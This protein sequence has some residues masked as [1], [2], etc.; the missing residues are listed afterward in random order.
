VKYIQIIFCTIII[1]FLG[2]VG[3][4]TLDNKVAS[5]QDEMRTYTMFP[6]LDY[7]KLTDVDYLT[8]IGD[9]FT[10]QLEWRWSFV[11]GY[12]TLTKDILHQS[13]LGSIVVGK[14]Q[15]L[16]NE[17][18]N[19]KNW[20]KYKKN[21]KKGAELLNEIAEEA[22][23]YGTKLIV[24]DAPR[25][26][27]ALR[28]YVPSWYPDITDQYEE[29][30]AIQR[31][32]LD[33]SIE[34]IDIKALFDE[35]NPEG[36]NRYWYYNDHHINCFGGELV[37][38][39]IIKIV[40][41]DYPQVEQKTLD[42]YQ[43]T[44]R[45]VYGALNRK[46]GLSATA[47][48]EPLNLLPDGWEINYERWDDGELTNAPIFGVDTETYSESYMGDNYGETIVKTDKEDLP[49]IYYCGSS[50]T[51]VLEAMSVP[52]FK[53]MY[54][55]DLRYND[56]GK[57]MMD[58]IKEFQPEYVVFV[59]GQSTATFNYKH[60]KMHLGVNKEEVDLD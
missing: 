51:N 29:C 18:I 24:L 49:S 5:S 3:I 23:Q 12:F 20:S 27:V 41:K 44:Y 8:Q 35:N 19:I 36:D 40:Q 59:S 54:S 58:Y 32:T 14:D 38:S 6:E 39:E 28:N 50:F 22:S 30:V 56:T 47:P 26:D 42:D 45:Q 11:K 37:L 55:T 7:S 43:I 15:V 13:T 33:D 60:L 31:E 57:T 21:V 48:D 9:A 53:N 17:P 46:I 1:A 52:S 10:D 16:F 4:C 2:I 25:R 34:L